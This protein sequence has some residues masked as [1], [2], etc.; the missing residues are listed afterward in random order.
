ML[1]YSFHRAHSR[2]ICA[3]VPHPFDT[4]CLASVGSD[5]AIC[6]WEISARAGDTRRGKRGEFRNILSNGPQSEM[7]QHGMPVNL[8]DAVYSP[9]GSSLAVADIVSRVK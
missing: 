8:L 2:T 3:L 9:D 1:L 7:F 4:A 6:T 5:G